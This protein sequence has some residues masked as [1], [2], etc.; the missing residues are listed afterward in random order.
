MKLIIDTDI[1]S[2]VDDALALA[3]AVKK[4]MDIPLLTTVH[5]D[6]QKR[7]AIAKKLT[8]LLGV[9]IPLAAGCEKPIKQYHLFWYGYEGAG[10]IDESE[11]AYF[12]KYPDAV[13]ALVECIH[14]NAGNIAIAAIGPLT[15]IARAYQ[16]DP[17]I[18][19]KVSILYMMGGAVIRPTEFIQSYRAH[20]FK[21]DPEA[22]D[23]VYE[24]ETPKVIVTTDV[25]K[26]SWLTQEDLRHWANS[27]KGLLE[28]LARGAE[29]WL[30]RSSYDIAYLYDPLTVAHHA[31]DFTERVTI[32][33]TSVTTDMKKDF[34]KEMY[35]T[36]SRS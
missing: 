31:D 29:C 18:A 33:N 12:T 15:N 6:T 16:R 20:N 17:G 5:G 36:L 4:G 13:D 34:K 21:V 26:K 30:A 19:S 3:Y 24:S 25:A 23:I 27:G 28:C 22:F 10:L 9:D 8:D 2:D 32:G 14:Q 11:R 35:E 1:G 7:A